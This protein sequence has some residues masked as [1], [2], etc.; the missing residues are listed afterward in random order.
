MG[1]YTDYRI[2][3]QNT[4]NELEL[5]TIIKDLEEISG[6]NF[7]GGDNEYQTNTKWYS[8]TTDIREISEKYPHILFYIE[9][10]GDECDDQWREFVQNGKVQHIDAKITFE[11]YDPSKMI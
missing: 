11:D 9:G 2:S 3:L 5:N 8:Y 1:Y 10:Q 6:E 4:S 7:E